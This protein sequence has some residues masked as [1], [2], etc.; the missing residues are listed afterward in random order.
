MSRF[1]GIQNQCI[2]FYSNGC[3]KNNESRGITSFL[4][5]LLAVTSQFSNI[6]DRILID[7]FVMRL[8]RKL[9]KKH[10]FSHVMFVCLLRKNYTFL[11]FLL[12]L[13]HPPAGFTSPQTSRHGEILSN[14]YERTYN[15]ES[16]TLVGLIAKVFLC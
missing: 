16:F 3:I 12:H 2:T 8:W 14:L 5:L 7:V 10:V 11:L 15:E 1:K 4:G 6:T 13:H 9:I